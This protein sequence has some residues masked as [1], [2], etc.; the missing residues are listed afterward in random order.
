[1]KRS[2]TL[3]VTALI[4]GLV[5]TQAFQ[6]CAQPFELASEAL[7]EA[8]MSMGANHPGS[9]IAQA[10]TQSPLLANRSYMT[11]LM[12]DVFTTDAMAAGDKTFVTNTLKSWITNQPAIY[13]YPC[14]KKT[15]LG[16]CNGTILTPMHSGT[17]TLRAAYKSQACQSILSK[18]VYVNAVV[19]KV[20]A[21]GA[22]PTATSISSLYELFYRGDDADMTMVQGLMASDK[23]I[24]AQNMSVSATDR[25]RY[26][27]LALCESPGWEQL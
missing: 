22:G 21:V 12:T 23:A 15:G 7:D 4:G 26:L 11:S 2:I 13:G 19:S 27:I 17:N 24:I 9:A 14:N 5:L 18:D 25:W 20:S 6:N 1:M 10:S 3:T 16:D 8:S